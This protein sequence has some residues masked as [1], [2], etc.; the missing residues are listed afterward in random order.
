MHKTPGRI[1]EMNKRNRNKLLGH[2]L[3]IFEIYRVVQSELQ[4][5]LRSG[6]QK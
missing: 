2:Y 6:V 1:S 3:V 4:G 5:G